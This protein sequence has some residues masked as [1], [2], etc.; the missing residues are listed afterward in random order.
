VPQYGLIAENVAEVAPD[1]VVR[2]ADGQPDTVRC[3]FLPPLLLAELQRLERDRAEMAK[4]LASLRAL[5]DELRAAAVCGKG[6]RQA[7]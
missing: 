6:S 5:V 4:D 3:R 2:G 7:A 1:L